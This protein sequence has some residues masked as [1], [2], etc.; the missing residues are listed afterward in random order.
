MI[1]RTLV[2]TRLILQSGNGGYWLMIDYNNNVSCSGT[3][4]NGA[5]SYMYA[6][7][8]RIGANDANTIYNETRVGINFLTGTSLADYKERM[9]INTAGRV[10]I[11][12][13]NPQ[14]MLHLGT[15][16]FRLA[17]PVVHRGGF[18]TCVPRA[19]SGHTQVPDLQ[20]DGGA[21]HLARRR[22]HS[23]RS[24]GPEPATVG[25]TRSHQA[26]GNRDQNSHNKCPPPT[27]KISQGKCTPHKTRKC[28]H[29]RLS[30]IRPMDVSDLAQMVPSI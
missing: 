22:H 18:G 17:A 5:T 14:S 27:R 6:G 4:T 11:S 16:E 12:N 3:I 24:S 25:A 19:W 30:V 21:R 10:G 26:R 1:L 15:C 23:P 7:G 13:T 2:N 20:P 29:N 28:K 9:T 8:L